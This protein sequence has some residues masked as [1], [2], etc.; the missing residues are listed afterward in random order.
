MMSKSYHNQANVKQGLAPLATAPGHPVDRNLEELPW[1]AAMEPQR[2]MSVEHPEIQATVRN[3]LSKN[4][5]L[6]TDR[7]KVQMVLFSLKNYVSINPEYAG[8]SFQDK[9]ELAGQMA[10]SFMELQAC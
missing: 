7:T 9:L 4:P 2:P 6:A 1:V 5:D 8:M 3:F 10:R